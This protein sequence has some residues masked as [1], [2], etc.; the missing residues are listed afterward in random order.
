M[1]NMW[2]VIGILGSISSII[3]IC[4]AV[5][6]YNLSNEEKEPYF[7]DDEIKT[8]LV[9]SENINKAP[10]KIYRSN[11]EEIVEDVSSTNFYF[12]NNGRQPIR[13]EDIL[14]S[15]VV[16]LDSTAEIL[17][18][19]LIST[20]REVCDI[21]LNQVGKNKLKIDFKILEKNDGLIGQV[22]FAGNPKQVLKL[23]GHIE[24]VRNFK[25]VESE[26]NFYF[27]LFLSLISGISLIIISFGGVVLFARLRAGTKSKYINQ[28]IADMYKGKDKEFIVFILIHLLLL[29]TISY[30]LIRKYDKQIDK[31]ET[32]IPETI[33]NE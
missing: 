4:L 3:G 29:S 23:N 10:I 27:I 30:S 25:S 28:A 16:S 8:K 24:G 2:K 13:K 19:E 15:L 7:F 21:D 33:K 26:N 11:G 9:D 5:Y 17:K 31:V 1:P 18:Y 14:D 20:S 6:F 32:L 12:W 22:I